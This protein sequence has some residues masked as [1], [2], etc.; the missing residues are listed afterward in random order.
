MSY[1]G[2]RVMKRKKREFLQGLCKELYSGALYIE[3]EC[4]E[5]EGCIERE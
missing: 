1:T 2:G 3:W 4:A 5:V